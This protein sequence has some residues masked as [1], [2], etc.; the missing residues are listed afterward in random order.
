MMHLRARR[1]SPAPPFDA[2]ASSMPVREAHG[3]LALVTKSASTGRRVI[4]FDGECNLC[5]AWVDFVLRH[6]RAGS[7]Q[8]AARQSVS[9]RR[10]LRQ[11]GA[12]P[13][14]PSSITLIHD[15]RV[16]I[17]SDAVWRIFRELPFPW[18]ALSALRLVPGPLRDLGYNV[19]ARSRY[20]LFGARESCRVL[21]AKDYSR[22]LS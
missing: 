8:F 5:N 10:L 17:R 16:Y 7:F 14:D 21:D 6:D 9:A 12:Q 11:M 4:I 19:V 13:D 1:G 18:F 22:F 15:G 2:G 3:G 20:R